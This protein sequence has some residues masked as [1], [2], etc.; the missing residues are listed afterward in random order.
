MLSLGHF[1]APIRRLIGMLQFA[2]DE[3]LIAFE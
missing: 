2:G 1:G 3:A